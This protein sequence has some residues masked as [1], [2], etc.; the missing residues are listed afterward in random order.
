MQRTHFEPEHDAFRDLC[1]TFFEKECAP[2][3]EEWE[4]AGKVD[5]DVW[6]K[7]GAA[8]MLLW[9][10]GEEHGGQGIRDYR[11]SQVLT[12]EM[13]GT[14][15]A[16]VG[17]GMQNDVMPP[18]LM[19]LATHE[20]KARWLPGSVSGDIIWGI[21]MSEPGAGSDLAGI[22]T[23]AIREGESYV[24]NGAK[25]FITNGLLLDKV[26]VVA[27]TDPAQAHKGISLVV[28]E[29]GMPGFTRG[30]HLDKIG[31]RSQDTAELFFDDV[32]VP[33]AN[34]LGEEGKG[35]GYLMR[36][37]PQ[38]RLGAGVHASATM[39]RAL[40]L[41]I[42]YVRTRK[43]FG[44]PIGAFQNTRFE[45]A[46]VKTLC[47]V[48]QAYVDKAV[49]EHVAG[50]LSPE[51]AAGLKQW[52]TDTQNR[53]IDRCLQ[54][55]GGYGYMN[56]YEIARLWRDA[57]VQRIYAGSNEVMKELVGRSLRLDGAP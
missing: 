13:V 24:V 31:Q 28:V 17:F 55:F 53:V 3:T 16:G 37:L 51:D 50:R 39:W 1:R 14:G 29:D 44:Q 10:A 5:R 2:H 45:L 22:R 12:E 46:E 35:F 30:R 38:E 41:T 34:L 7:A 54:L 47:E 20:Q 40:H 52:T 23:T 25:T 42:D 26:V 11:Y 9:E 15:S 8:G 57:R 32:R 48:V 6:R 49:V 36:N 43:A 21:A 19:D 27:K 18:Y 33:V 4:A 56:E